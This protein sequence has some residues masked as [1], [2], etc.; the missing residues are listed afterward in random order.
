M[1]NSIPRGHLFGI[2]KMSLKCLEG[3]EFNLIVNELNNI[4]IIPIGIILK[5]A[6]Q[7]KSACFNYRSLGSLNY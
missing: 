7:Y 6:L 1:N 2:Y 4:T 5:E 3:V